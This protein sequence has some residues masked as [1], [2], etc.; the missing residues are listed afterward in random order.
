[1][2]LPFILIL[3]IPLFLL[4][5]LNSLI[6]AI[7]FL[8]VIGVR[9]LRFNSFVVEMRARARAYTSGFKAR[10]L[11]F[12]LQMRYKLAYVIIIFKNFEPPIR[13]TEQYTH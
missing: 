3:I 12:L 6:L 10:V 4:N 9:Y 5:G 7:Y 2:Y 8:G 1:M 11:N 13:V